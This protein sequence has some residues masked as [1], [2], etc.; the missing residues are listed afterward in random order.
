MAA[1]LDLYA[2]ETVSIPAGSTR[3]IYTDLAVQVPE[4]T[5]G[6]VAPR[7]GLAVRHQLGV[8]AGVIDAD[9]TGNLGV[10]IYNHGQTVYTVREGDRIAQLIC[11]RIAY[12]VPVQCESLN[13][14]DRGNCGFGSTDEK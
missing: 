3:V 14:T 2:A 4:G 8:E 9:Y 12:P 7:S 6:R 10:V 1:G 11:E 5:Y 13:A